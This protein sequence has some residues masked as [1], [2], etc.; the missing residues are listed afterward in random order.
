MSSRHFHFCF[1]FF[2]L[3]NP[4]IWSK[5]KEKKKYEN[6]AKNFFSKFLYQN[7]T[8]S[9]ETGEKEKI[10]GVKI[11]FFEKTNKEDAKKCNEIECFKKENSENSNF[12][13]EI[14]KN[15]EKKKKRTKKFNSTNTGKS[16]SQKAVMLSRKTNTTHLYRNEQNFFG[17]F[18]R[19]RVYSYC[20]KLRSLFKNIFYDNVKHRCSSYMSC[21]LLHKLSPNTTSHILSHKLH[22]K[23]SFHS[24]CVF[25][26]PK[27]M[28]YIGGMKA[29]KVKNTSSPWEEEIHHHGIRKICFSRENEKISFRKKCSLSDHIKCEK[30]EET[31]NSAYYSKKDGASKKPRMRRK[32]EILKQKTEKKNNEKNCLKRTQLKKHQ[33]MRHRRKRSGPNRKFKLKKSKKKHL[34]KNGCQKNQKIIDEIIHV[35]SKKINKKI[36]KSHFEKCFQVNS[37]KKI[38]TINKKFKKKN[39]TKSN[40]NGK[41]SHKKRRKLSSRKSKRYT[42]ADND[43]KPSPNHHHSGSHLPAQFKCPIITFLSHHRKIMQH[44]PDQFEASNLLQSKNL[45]TQH[46]N[47]CFC[48]L[49]HNI[50]CFNISSIPHFH[51]SQHVF[52]AFIAVN[53]N[54][55]SLPQNSFKNLNVKKL[56]L[57]FNSLGSLLS[58]QALNGLG[59][60]LEELHLG[61]CALKTL[62]PHFIEDLA[63]LTK[64]HIWA[65]KLQEIPG[66]F[67][68]KSRNLQELIVWGNNISRL[69]KDSFAGLWKLKRLDLDRNQIEEL[70]KEMFRHL[71]SLEVC[72]VFVFRVIKF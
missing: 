44:H 5:L 18:L 27:H 28:G 57:G 3:F 52:H 56:F 17:N 38:K 58:S 36:P 55:T 34:S 62:P 6:S 24:P 14:I 48:T 20:H 68:K 12:F 43:D 61:A 41:K 70:D 67:F 40:I 31:Y 60:H 10:L 64:F 33:L 7:I 39:E 47:S 9:G 26:S 37:R 30:K 25:V 13:P 15:F 35:F 49:Q 4:I 45:I 66:K 8:F 23:F 21:Q 54:I 63:G 69:D 19:F 51:P 29:A 42:S 59:E 71:N 16:S 32:V 72:G 50:E 1:L 11:K 65:N 22:Q 46:Y 53:Q 2:F